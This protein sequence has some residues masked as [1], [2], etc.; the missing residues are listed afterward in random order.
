MLLASTSIKVSA[1]LS[2]H[3]SVCY[4]S[5]SKGRL[6]ATL[7]T[8][9]TVFFGFNLHFLP[10]TALFLKDLD[11]FHIATDINQSG[12]RHLNS[13]VRLSLT[14]NAL[15]NRII[16]TIFFINLGL[17]LEFYLSIIYVYY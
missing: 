3:K 12:S 17:K 16:V 1:T 13:I 14:P 5:L 7:F 8:Q 11:R 10:L 4:T 2:V 15:F 6:A 9:E